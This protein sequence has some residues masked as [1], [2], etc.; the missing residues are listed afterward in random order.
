[1][2]KQAEMC[3]D[4][5]HHFTALPEDGLWAGEMPCGGVLHACTAAGKASTPSTRDPPVLKHLQAVHRA[6]LENSNTIP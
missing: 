6:A 2:E 4:G 5:F 3:S 1:M